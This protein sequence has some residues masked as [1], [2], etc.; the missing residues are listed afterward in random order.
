MFCEMIFVVLLHYC[1]LRFFPVRLSFSI[2]VVTKTVI[3]CDGKPA[4]TLFSIYIR[5]TVDNWTFLVT[6]A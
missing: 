6:A 3:L 4:V 1:N 5:S 2:H